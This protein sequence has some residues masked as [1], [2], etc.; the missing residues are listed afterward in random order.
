MALIPSPKQTLILVPFLALL[1]TACNAINT[2]EREHLRQTSL[3]LVH[4]FENLV[5]FYG[6][7]RNVT[8]SQEHHDALATVL[9]NIHGHLNNIIE[10]TPDNNTEETMEEASGPR[11]SS[12]ERNS[13][14]VIIPLSITL[15]ALAFFPLTTEPEFRPKPEKLPKK[16]VEKQLVLER[17]QKANPIPDNLQVYLRE[18]SGV[19]RKHKANARDLILQLNPMPQNLNKG[20]IP[21]Q[22]NFD[23]NFLPYFTNSLP[24]WREYQASEMKFTRTINPKIAPKD[25]QNIADWH[26]YL[27]KNYLT[28]YA[29]ILHTKPGTNIGPLFTRLL[30]ELNKNARSLQVITKKIRQNR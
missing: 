18:I 3:R 7:Q 21:L 27:W 16:P 8:F 23:R 11:F 6:N 26:L 2:A 29:Q 20:T 17:I 9:H 13:L 5:S 4:V 1:F 15:A 30:K 19:V 24:K 14:M 22:E 25:Y 10:G 12:F 28:K